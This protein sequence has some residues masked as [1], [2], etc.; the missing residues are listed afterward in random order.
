MY[1]SL[2]FRLCFLLQVPTQAWC[3]FW[4]T[5]WRMMALGLCWSS[6]REK[7]WPQSPTWSC[8]IVKGPTPQPQTAV[9]P[10]CVPGPIWILW[11]QRRVWARPTEPGWTLEPQTGA[12]VPP[13]VVDWT[14]GLQ[15]EASAPSPTS[16]RDW[17][18]M[19]L[20]PASDPVL[21]LGLPTALVCCQGNG[22]TRGHQTTVWV[23]P[24]R[25]RVQRRRWKWPRVVQLTAQIQKPR[26]EAKIQGASRLGPS[27]TVPLTSLMGLF[28]LGEILQMACS[29]AAPREKTTSRN[30]R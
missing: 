29:T 6:L 13:S 25:R 30:K 3:W 5:W 20:T 10:R 27:R 16:D 19:S 28:Y 4:I 9:W 22:L 1:L 7:L 8:L 21:A 15:S 11:P 14:L 17:A 2:V 23:C 18:Q 26:E 24:L 12:I